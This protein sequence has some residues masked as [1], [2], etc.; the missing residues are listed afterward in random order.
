MMNK[1]GR[2]ADA[3]GNMFHSVDV[4]D[5]SV[6]HLSAFERLQRRWGT[7][8]SILFRVTYFFIDYRFY[9]SNSLSYSDEERI[10]DSHSQKQQY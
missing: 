8:V 6:I 10:E 2:K 1:N 9:S 4:L 3:P 5:F 7:F